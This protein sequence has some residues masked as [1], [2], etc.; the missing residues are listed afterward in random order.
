MRLHAEIVE[1]FG[2][3][4][5]T[6]KD[7]ADERVHFLI[8]RLAAKVQEEGIKRAYAEQLSFEDLRRSGTSDPS[9]SGEGF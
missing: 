2:K 6:I 1:R 8:G 4:V 5:G 9:A 3:I 7:D